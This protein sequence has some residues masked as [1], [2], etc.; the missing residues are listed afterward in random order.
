M[1]KKQILR[2]L[3]RID[4]ETEKYRIHSIKDFIN[5]DKFRICIDA[6]FFKEVEYYVEGS[7]KRKPFKSIEK[8]MKEAVYDYDG[9]GFYYWIPYDNPPKGFTSPTWRMMNL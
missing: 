8:F 7:R 5:D 4:K 1:N 2:L 6:K 3:D 9:Q